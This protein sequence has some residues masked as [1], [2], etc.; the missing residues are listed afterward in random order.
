M[1]ETEV[2]D[3]PLVRVGWP[4]IFPESTYAGM[5]EGEDPI[6]T[7]CSECGEI[8]DWQRFRRI[9]MDAAARHARD[10]HDDDVDREGW[11]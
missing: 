7:D 8:I 1:E 6:A 2:S 5:T 11:A 10:V 3:R 4:D 9:A